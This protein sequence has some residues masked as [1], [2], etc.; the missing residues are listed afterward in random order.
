M[1]VHA[2]EEQST[3]DVDLNLGAVKLV[4]KQIYPKKDPVNSEI[5]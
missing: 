2:D 1:M 3:D 5:C 4:A